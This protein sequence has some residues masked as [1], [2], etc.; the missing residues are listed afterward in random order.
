M[1]NFIQPGEYGLTVIA[2]AAVTSG[3]VVVVGNIVGIAACSAGAGA[4]VEVATEGIF[5]LAKIPADTHAAG[6]IAK[7]DGSGNVSL[8]GT[9][10]I[11]WVVQAAA[12]GSA[13]ARVKLC[14]GIA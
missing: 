10:D 3:Q 1:K 5:D 9:K 2:P 6:D 8:A 13:T 7:V 11:G 12:A 14:P 4:Q